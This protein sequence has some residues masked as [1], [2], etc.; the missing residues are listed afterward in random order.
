[1]AFRNDTRFSKGAVLKPITFPMMVPNIQ[2][3]DEPG[4]RS[5]TASSS[6]TG[7][8]RRPVRH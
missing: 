8:R 4:P 3:Y 6:E 5:A 7:R 1:M 2:G